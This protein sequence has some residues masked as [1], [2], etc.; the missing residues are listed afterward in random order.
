MGNLLSKDIP[1]IYPT[2]EELLEIIVSKQPDINRS[3]VMEALVSREEMVRA[4]DMGHFY[5]VP[6]D[7]RDLNYDKYV[8]QGDETITQKEEYTSY[9]TER[10]SK[11]GVIE[12]LLKLDYIQKELSSKEYIGVAK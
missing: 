4:I 3:E 6:A 12:T 10:L 5:R 1:T 8:I 2:K 11:D 7:G 9:N